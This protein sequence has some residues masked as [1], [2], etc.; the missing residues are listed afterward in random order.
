[1]NHDDVRLLRSYL[2]PDPDPD[3]GAGPPE[4]ALGVVRYAASSAPPML[5]GGVPVVTLHMA[6]STDEQFREVWQS[7]RP[8]R[9]GVHRGLVFA[10]DGEYLLCAGNIPLSDSC[11]EATRGAYDAAFELIRDL[12]Y[13]NV[14][15][16]WNFVSD[17]TAKN[18]AGLEVYQEFCA[19]RAEAYEANP[20]TQHMMSAATGIGALGGGISFHVLASRSGRVTNIENSRQVPSYRYPRRYGPKPPSFARAS[21]LSLGGESTVFVSGTASIL[22]HET[23]HPGDV[24]MQ[25]RTTLENIEHLISADNL[26][27]Y[28]LP[29]HRL[30]DLRQVKVY[31]KH[32]SDLDLVTKVC[33][34]VLSPEV[35]PAVFGVDICRSD[36]L[37]EIEGIVPCG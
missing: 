15:R 31:V 22:G 37:V 14:F 32:R 19:S 25:C 10:H 8:A 33:R 12:G 24:E 16:L 18:S 4:G 2:D 6:E 1:M 35:E 9:S 27:P 34:E 3:D 13:P 20:E 21:H 36:L 30:H 28:G 23:A 17:I 5:E 26:A 11:R 7:G 29:G